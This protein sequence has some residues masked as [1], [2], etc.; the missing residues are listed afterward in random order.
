ML[1]WT[2]ESSPY[3][4]LGKK[5]AKPL[6]H[7]VSL[8]AALRVD[9]I[10]YSS[11]R[12]PTLEE[13][14]EE[15]E[16][17]EVVER[18]EEATKEEREGGEG[19]RIDAVMEEN[20]L[21]DKQRFERINVVDQRSYLKQA[22][23]VPV[24]HQISH[25]AIVASDISVSKTISAA[26]VNNNNS[27]NSSNG[28][29]S[30][31]S[32]TN[33][34]NNCS[35]ISKEDSHDRVRP[36]ANMRSSASAIANRIPLKN[37]ESADPRTSNERLD[38]DILVA[39]R[40]SATT[41]SS[42]IP[43]SFP[44]ST[45]SFSSVSMRVAENVRDGRTVSRLSR[46]APLPVPLPVPVPVPARRITAPTPAPSI[47]Q[48]KLCEVSADGARD[49][50]GDR[51]AIDRPQCLLSSLQSVSIQGD[52]H[53][54]S[55]SATAAAA[56]VEAVAAVAVTTGVVKGK[57]GRPRKVELDKP[58]DQTDS[59]HF[60]VPTVPTVSKS[61][62]FWSS[63]QPTNTNGQTDAQPLKNSLCVSGPEDKETAPWVPLPV[64]VSLPLPLHPVT[65]QSS[66]HTHI[67]T[68]L[69]VVSAL[70]LGETMPKMQKQHDGKLQVSASSLKVAFDN[71]HEYVIECVSATQQ[72]HPQPQAQRRVSMRNR[73]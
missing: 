48:N 41:S 31:S 6:L 30:S 13:E 50:D 26:R 61:R 46:H 28:N 63:P 2:L 43:P 14:E 65:A 8:T 73:K 56:A 23:K 11:L 24:S 64:P 19:V 25:S 39:K 34:S 18:E 49:D 4:A 33:N 72:S 7:R 22:A 71:E 27:N 21:K 17:E 5:Y 9:N 51:G 37:V 1:H 42:V 44:S 16:E 60:S 66:S 32:C 40:S 38:L 12:R 55:S 53:Q 10:R 29:T 54:S 57:R 52:T 35:S 15:E 67:T 59:T 47:A 62:R 3:A 68:S 58:L 69:P 36:M 45:S 70:K 20:R